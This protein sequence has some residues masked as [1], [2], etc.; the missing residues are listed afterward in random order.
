MLSSFSIAE[1]E[2]KKMSLEALNIRHFESLFRIGKSGIQIWIWGKSKWSIS[3]L[4][5]IIVVRDTRNVSG[6][7]SRR[8]RAGN[9]SRLK[10]RRL[11]VE[12]VSGLKSRRLRAGNVSGLK[13]CRLHVGNGLTTL[14]FLY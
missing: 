13:S 4:V 1:C 10:S 9:V 6:L 14:T 2:K 11:H 5:L 3:R 8:L 12:N 7:K